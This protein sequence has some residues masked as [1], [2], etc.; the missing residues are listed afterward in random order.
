M[1]A[2]S[3]EDIIRRIRSENP[4][5][6]GDHT[7]NPF[8][9][10]MRRR[11][12]FELFFPL[13][14]AKSVRRAVVLMGPRRVGK[15]VMIHHAI[16]ALLDEGVPPKSICYFSVDHPIYNGLRLEQLLD[17]YGRSSGLEYKSEQIYVFFD[18][19]QYLRRWEQHVKS[20]VDTH[21]NIKC[22]VSG[23]A[24]AALR[25]KSTE[26]GAGR[27]TDF[28]LPPL[29]FYEY[30]YLLDKTDL[31][32]LQV[33]SD[34]DDKRRFFLAKN[35]EQLNEQFLYY[36]NFGGYPEVIFS[37]QIQADPSRF[38]K[39][40]IIDKVLLRDLPSLY[41]IGDI[42][43]LNYLF[44][45]LAFNTANEISLGELSKNSGVAK[46]TIKRYIEYLE[47]AFLIKI[48]HRVD[49]NAKRFHRAN[50]FK[51]YLTNP[52][53][54]AALFSPL[55]ADDPTIASL[56]ETAI[57][58]Q[59]F[60]SENVV[61]Y[62]RW[63]DGEVDIVMLGAKQKA[64]WAVEVKWSD[65][66]CENPGE[67]K[68]LVGFCQSNGLKKSLVTSKTKALTCKVGKLRIVFVPASSYCYTVGYN[69]IHGKKEKGLRE[70]LKAA[71]PI[72]DSVDPAQSDVP[73]PL[74]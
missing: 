71:V 43:E 35:I 40:D 61:N 56:A 62:A 6:E 17:F 39:S 64:I 4:W 2:I 13:A 31:L 42:Q 7:I 25:L 44:T 10:D 57:F 9:Q 12:Y 46:N 5:W 36:L 20:V 11:P 23:S 49:R 69:L 68:S 54:R 47:A 50:F 14:K 63:H 19:I 41:G 8:F 60:H 1:E 73:N 55:K 72:A 66:Y 74:Q 16:R 32:E 15:T 53:M 65:R 51:V 3:P 58:S 67:L 48:V 22:I 27:F 26:S 24:A 38:I 59:W 21:S 34:P 29:T 28:L 33:N 37:P 45:T 52:S 18:E 30:L 70:Q